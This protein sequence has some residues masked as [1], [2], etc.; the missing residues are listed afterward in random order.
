MA[1]GALSLQQAVQTNR[2]RDAA[3]RREHGTYNVIAPWI[4]TRQIAL[5]RADA[6][7]PNAILHRAADGYA[8]PLL[9]A[10]APKAVMGQSGCHE[11]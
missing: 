2:T 7:D 4:R 5:G 10:V 9:A 1:Q 8:Q 3:R 6:M 11:F